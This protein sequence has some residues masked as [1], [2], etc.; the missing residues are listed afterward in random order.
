M[1]FSVEPTSHLL[2]GTRVAQKSAPR[3]SASA[4]VQYRNRDVPGEYWL[5]AG[6]GFGKLKASGFLLRSGT[7]RVIGTPPE[8]GSSSHASIVVPLPVSDFF[9]V[10]RRLLCLFDLAIFVPPD[11]RTIFT[12]GCL[13][14]GTDIVLH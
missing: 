3:R 7:A 9:G 10:D 12:R 6:A 2:S 5:G 11:E 14:D 1:T 8:P 4:A 13:N